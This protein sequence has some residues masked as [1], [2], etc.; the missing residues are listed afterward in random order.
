MGKGADFEREVAR[1]L[2]LW[3]SYGARDD[4]IWRTSQ[5]GGRA[6]QRSKKDKPTAGGYGDLAATDP[7]A[8]PLFQFFTV[9][10]K[11]GRS[12]GSPDDLL[13]AAPTDKQRPFERC[14]LQAVQAHQAA[15]SRSWLLICRRDRREAVVYGEACVFKLLPGVMEGPCVRYDMR[16]NQLQGEPVRMRFVGMRFDSFLT[17]AEPKAIKALK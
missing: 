4:L 14:L 9:E 6:T 8:A 17:R 16:I 3:W 2:S 13:D 1:K 5:S 7:R 15:R 11:R 10:L 12:H